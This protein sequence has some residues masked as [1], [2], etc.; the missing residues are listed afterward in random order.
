MAARCAG[1]PGVP[2]S[3]SRSGALARTSWLRLSSNWPTSRVSV[4]ASSTSTTTGFFRHRAVNRSVRSCADPSGAAHSAWP[5]P[6]TPS[7]LGRIFLMTDVGNNASTTACPFRIRLGDSRATS[8]RPA[9]RQ[10]SANQLSSTVLPLPRGPMSAT[11]CGGALP[12]S[13]S[14]RHCASTSC[15]RSRPVSAGGAAPAP[16]VNTRCGAL[17]AAAVRGDV[18]AQSRPVGPLSFL[19]SMQ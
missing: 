7:F 8:T 11:S 19:E 9:S 1:R 15:S 16:G 12:P 17:M 2:A 14:A 3:T 18:L 10:A 5:T 4:W 6:A 13:R